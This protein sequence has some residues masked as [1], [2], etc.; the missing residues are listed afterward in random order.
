L[1]Q[2]TFFQGKTVAVLADENISWRPQEYI[3]E[4]WGCKVRFTFPM[5]KLNDYS[6]KIE[7]L[8]NEAN[9]FAI[10]TA[11]HL[12]TR[13]TKGDP[14]KRYAWRWKITTALYERGFSRQDILEIYRL[15]DWFMMLPEDLTR[16]FTEHLIDYEISPWIL[17]RNSGRIPQISGTLC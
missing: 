8:L 7:S 4:Q 12:K 11:A 1:K 16:R 10:I 14:Q 5:V 6:D 15:I 17:N 13:A 3:I 9:P 2:Q